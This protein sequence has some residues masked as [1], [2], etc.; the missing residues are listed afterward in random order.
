M[1]SWCHFSIG[2]GLT[3]REERLFMDA[4]YVDGA[5]IFRHK[6]N[7]VFYAMKYVTE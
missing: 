2:K 4:N 1:S 7:Y 6:E 3:F 5:K